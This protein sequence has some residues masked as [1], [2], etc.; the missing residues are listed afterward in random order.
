MLEPHPPVAVHVHAVRLVVVRTETTV[1]LEP[2]EKC[3]FRLAN[4]NLD[5]GMD[6]KKVNQVL[7]AIFFSY[8]SLYK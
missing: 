3:L 4:L 6:N 8:K 7:S 1:A 5:L 2:G